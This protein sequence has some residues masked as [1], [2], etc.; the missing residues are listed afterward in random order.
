MTAGSSPPLDPFEDDLTRELPSALRTFTDLAPLTPE[1]SSEILEV[2]AEDILEIVEERGRLLRTEQTIRIPRPASVPAFALDVPPTRAPNA[3]DNPLAVMIGAALLIACSVA[4]A[5]GIFAGRTLAA[6]DRVA[7][8][9]QPRIA[10]VAAAREVITIPP[11]T[12]PDKEVP[13]LPA[14]PPPPPRAARPIARATLV[15]TPAPSAAPSTSGRGHLGSDREPF[16]DRGTT[17]R[18]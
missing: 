1:L 14:P 17:P 16:R 10:V 15:R 11:L 12:A 7:D 2:A 3:W 4:G 8:A 5:I 9:R 6:G 13:L 18:R